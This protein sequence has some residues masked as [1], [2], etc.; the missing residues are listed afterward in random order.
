[1][2]ID[3]EKQFVAPRV[4]KISIFTYTEKKETSDHVPNTE[5]LN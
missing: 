3:L 2:L 5:P 1:M 4:E